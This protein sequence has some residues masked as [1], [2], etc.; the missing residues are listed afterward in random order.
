MRS[1][2][3]LAALASLLALAHP[4]GAALPPNAVYAAHG[5]VATADFVYD[6]PCVGEGTVTLVVHSAGGD[7]TLTAAVTSSAVGAT[8]GSGLRCNGCPPVPEAFEWELKGDG[9]LLVGGGPAVYDTYADRP[10]AF[11]L[12]GTFLG[13]DLE[14]H[15]TIPL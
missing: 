15:G 7:Q 12:Q 13:G 5:A 6:G 1:L 2:V 8:C 9:V 3:P 10:V 14:A 4:V 11:Q